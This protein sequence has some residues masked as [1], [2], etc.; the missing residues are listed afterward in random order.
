MPGIAMDNIAEFQQR[1]ARFNPVY[2]QHWNNWLKTPDQYRPQEL[3]LILGRWQACRGNSI[4]QLATTGT[5]IHPAPYIEDLFVQ[6][7]PH[8]KILSNFNMA[9]PDSFNTETIQALHELWKT[10]EKLSYER[11]NPARKKKAPRQGLTGVVGISK[12]TMLVTNGRVGPA[13][14]SK[15]RDGLQLK[16][17]IENASDWIKALRTASEDI[18]AFETINKTTLQIASRL[19]LPAG[20]I[21]DMA[22]GPTKVL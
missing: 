6:A 22:L 11:F 4:R 10:F 3:K 1:I 21:Y 2:V 15:V 17:K 7:L 13:F 19:D 12:A 8:A 18:C 5:T 16:R 20:R 14:D 9:K